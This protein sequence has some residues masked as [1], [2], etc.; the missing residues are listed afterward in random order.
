MT[1]HLTLLFAHGADVKVDFDLSF[2]AQIALFGLF[3]VILR[4]VLFEPMMKLFEE[5]EKRTDGTR[6]EARKMD[7]KAASLVAK[8]EGEVE[9]VRHAANVER[10]RLRAETA[11]LEAR[12]LAEAKDSSNAIIEKGRAQIATE[13][14][15]LRAELAAARPQL[16]EQIASKILG[17]EVSS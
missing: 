17:R 15:A 2:I 4:P 3:I 7:E 14:A 9:K 1:N 16:A 5:R 8:F 6:G 13:V 10:D 11:K 12:I